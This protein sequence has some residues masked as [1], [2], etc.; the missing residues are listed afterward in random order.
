MNKMVWLAILD[1]SEY[2]ANFI[3]IG[4]TKDEALAEVKKAWI[5]Y[6]D[7]SEW[8]ELK[9]ETAFVDISKNRAFYQSRDLYGIDA[10][11]G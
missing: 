9:G 4:S 6:A 2:D 5:V 7:E 10:V 1:S 8:D 11:K 3:G